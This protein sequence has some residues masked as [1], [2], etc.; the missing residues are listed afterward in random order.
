MARTR[1]VITNTYQAV[2]ALKCMI[3]LAKTPKTGVV[4][5][6]DV[7][8]DDDTAIGMKARE[9]GEQMQQTADVITYMRSETDGFEVI[10]DDNV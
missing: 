2:S 7:N 9:L 10:V 3:T 6:N 5:F 1:V 8:T 4:L